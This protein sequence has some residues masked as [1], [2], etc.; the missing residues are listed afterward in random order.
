ME[1]IS[2][3]T[4]CWFEETATGRVTW[5]QK[6]VAPSV[7]WDRCSPVTMQTS[8]F[9]R[10]DTPQGHRY[11]LWEQCDLY[12]ERTW[13]SRPFRLFIDQ[14]VSVTLFVDPE[15]ACV[16]VLVPSCMG[17]TLKISPGSHPEVDSSRARLCIS[18]VDGGMVSPDH[19]KQL[20]L[21]L[22]AAH[23]AGRLS[24][25]ALVALASLPSPSP[26]GSDPNAEGGVISPTDS[27]YDSI[28]FL[29]GC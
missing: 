3:P 11:E 19:V 23:S 13:T 18:V 1:Y 8:T 9:D 10:M 2:Q 17:S 16:Y 7:C 22:A 14:E 28:Q 20:F 29:T 15:I 21:D 25:I 5:I 26:L 24:D 6:G 4:G 27:E 12:S